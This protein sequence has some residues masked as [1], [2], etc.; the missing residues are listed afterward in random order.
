MVDLYRLSQPKN[1]E[2]GLEASYFPAMFKE[3]QTVHPCGYSDADSYASLAADSAPELSRSQKFASAFKKVGRLVYDIVWISPMGLIRKAVY[4]YKKATTIK[5]IAEKRAREILSTTSPPVHAAYRQHASFYLKKS[6]LY[7]FVG[8]C[9]IIRYVFTGPAAVLGYL[10]V[11]AVA[12]FSFT[13][14]GG[15]LGLIISLTNMT[16]ASAKLASRQNQ[17]EGLDDIAKYIRALESQLED[18]QIPSSEKIKIRETKDLLEKFSEKHQERLKNKTKYSTIRLVASTFFWASSYLTIVSVFFPPLHIVALGMGL[19][20][21]VT[22]GIGGIMRFFINR[23]IRMKEEQVPLPD[24]Y[25]GLLI[26][27]AAKIQNEQKGNDS[28][29]IFTQLIANKLF[30]TN[31]LVFD[32]LTESIIERVD[33]DNSFQYERL[34]RMHQAL[35]DVK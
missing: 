32:K 8:A 2:P 19:T 6:L 13:V 16:S 3:P 18:L 31:P 10:G 25:H 12:A 7:G 22:L 1:W 17:Q 35:L 24:T 14:T 20:S 34:Q 21:L 9:S 30:D 15:I 23:N 11:G 28:N 27:V 26:L 33:R 4:H 5:I 29:K